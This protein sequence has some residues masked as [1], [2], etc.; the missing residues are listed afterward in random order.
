MRTAKI[1][2][3]H[4]AVINYVYS[5]YIHSLYLQYPKNKLNISI[6]YFKHILSIN[7]AAVSHKNKYR[8]LQLYP[9][10]KIG[11]SFD[12][13]KYIIRINLKNI[14]CKDKTILFTVYNGFTYSL[15]FVCT[16][17]IHNINKVLKLIKIP[18]FRTLKTLKNNKNKNIIYINNKFIEFT[19]T[20]LFYVNSIEFIKNSIN[21][22]ILLYMGA[23]SRSKNFT[24]SGLVLPLLLPYKVE[25]VNVNGISYGF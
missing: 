18:I 23:R 7:Q 15:S 3:K 11:L 21:S 25:K 10:F 22:S 2:N 8:L 13:Y 1:F 5:K 12:Y 17:Y 4:S 6:V 9:D 20:F 14:V 19:K 16:K 24:L